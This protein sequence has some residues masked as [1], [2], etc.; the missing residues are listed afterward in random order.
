MNT[1]YLWMD[2]LEDWSN[3]NGKKC[4]R[5]R[6]KYNTKVGLER[7]F[8]GGRGRACSLLSPL[9]KMDLDIC[10]TGSFLNNFFSSS[11]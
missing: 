7:I 4:N 9:R 8:G 6:G 3:R 5:T 2:L 10:L 11:L 1:K